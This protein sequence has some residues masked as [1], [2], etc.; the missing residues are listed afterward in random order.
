MKHPVDELLPNS[1][2][3]SLK[4]LLAEQIQ[5]PWYWRLARLLGALFAPAWRAR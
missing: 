1:R 5:E 2:M 4:A 3:Q